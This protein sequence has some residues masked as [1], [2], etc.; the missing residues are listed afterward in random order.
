MFDMI[1]KKI[2]VMFITGV[3][4]LIVF[5]PITNAKYIIVQKSP[6]FDSVIKKSGFF[7]S[8]MIFKKLFFSLFKTGIDDFQQIKPK[9]VS[10]WGER[11]PEGDCQIAV[12]PDNNYVYVSGNSMSFSDSMRPFLVKY[13][14]SGKEI[15]SKILFDQEGAVFSVTTE[16]GYVYATGLVYTSAGDTDVFIVKYNSVGDKI[17]FKKWDGSSCDIGFSVLC[18]GDRIY[19]AG[20]TVYKYTSFDVLLLCFRDEGSTCELMW[21]KI[22]GGDK[23]DVALGMTFYDNKLYLCGT[24]MGLNG[25]DTH[26]SLLLKFD[27]SN[28]KFVVFDIWSTDDY[29]QFQDI[30]VRDGSLFVVGWTQGLSHDYDIV[31]LKY[32]LETEQREWGRTWG[33]VMDNIGFGVTVS[34]DHVYVVGELCDF[35]GMIEKRACVVLKFDF[36]G[37]LIW[38]KTWGKNVFA[39][40]NDITFYLGNLYVCGSCI[41]GFKQYSDV[42]VFKCD[43]NGE[44]SK[45][46]F[47]DRI[48]CLE[49]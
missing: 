6:S 35:S 24:T 17:W 46:R 23:D 18:V 36:D 34:N 20:R 25:K 5:I 4:L 40:G 11:L 47:L 2:Y 28:D 9:W 22:W 19:V 1:S 30:V 14:L 37:V 32:N 8:K 31:L 10:Y 49:G 27:A 43:K 12:D 3:L 15:W 39:G 7:H 45:S 44:R 41:P 38:S 26:D 21:F 16:R 13:D 48:F 29:D 42:F 33:E